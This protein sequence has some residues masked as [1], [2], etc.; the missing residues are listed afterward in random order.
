MHEKVLNSTTVSVTASLTAEPVSDRVSLSD[1]DSMLINVDITTDN[2]VKK[3]AISLKIQDSADAAVWNTKKSVAVTATAEVQTLTVDTKANTVD[4]DYIVITDIIGQAWAVA[5][6]TT[7][8]STNTP[9][10]AI[11]TA[12]DGAFKT[13]ANISADV[14]EAQ[15]AARVETA[16]NSLTGFSDVVTTN[17]GAN[18]GTMTLTAV[19]AGPN[20]A[21]GQVLAKDDTAAAT[22]ALAISTTTAPV[23][24]GVF[25]IKL[26]PDTGDDVS[27]DRAFLPL[28][29]F[30]RI[31]AS[32]GAGDSLDI[33][34]VRVSQRR[35]R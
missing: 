14:T 21:A 11:W 23:D 6:D 8:N 10:G 28:R 27:G 17:D 24:S 26:M 5:F 15:V 19:T 35:S 29:P 30:L 33:T 34:S 13:E 12:I 22:P 16:F 9:T 32:T 3:T 20:M 4:G 31:I 18:D 25:T 7:G 2:I 1:E